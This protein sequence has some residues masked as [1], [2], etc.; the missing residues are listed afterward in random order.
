[1]TTDSNEIEHLFDGVRNGST[2]AMEKLLQ[3][4]EP[5]LRR[6]ARRSCSSADVDDAVQDAMIIIYQRAGALKFLV[7]LSSWL[8]KIVLRICMRL[9]KG[10]GMNDQFDPEAHLDTNAMSLSQTAILQQELTKM[11]MK[12]DAHYR[13]ILLLRD[14]LGYSAE[15]TAER[16][17]ISIDAAKSRLHRARALA[18]KELNDDFWQ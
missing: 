2:L 6:Y 18:R 15:E 10:D 11:L 17:N 14:F 12:I 4:L 13:E 7:A 5:D 1:M 3:K 9:K 8:F 16:L